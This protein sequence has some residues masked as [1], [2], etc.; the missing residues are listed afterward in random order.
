MRTNT[1]ANS[2]GIVASGTA[3]IAGLMI[4]GS[5]SFTPLTSFSDGTG[6]ILDLSH[7][8]DWQGL[9][10]VRVPL[11]IEFD[12]SFNSDEP[13]DVRTAAQHME[14][15]RSILS[16]T[17]A[18][19]AV[20]FSVSRQAMY[21]WIN[22]ESEPEPGNLERIK[23]LSSVADAFRGARVKR[24]AAL[25]KMKA[26]NGRSL[27]DLITSDQIR[28]E[29]IQLLISEAESMERTYDRSGLAR[30][31]ATPSSDW[32]SNISIPGAAED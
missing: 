29:Q 28:P 2:P 26:F 30:S 27:L 13:L 22:D 14:N 4:Y 7:V 9:I 15:I 11:D 24:P 18:D 16:P 25:L 19:L 5:L 23:T 31:K 6:S 1:F 21:N 17:I 3:A 20:V 12:P 10:R 32:Q 8:Q